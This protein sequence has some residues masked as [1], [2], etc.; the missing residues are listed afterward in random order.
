MEVLDHEGRFLD[1]VPCDTLTSIATVAR[2]HDTA[3][4]L[5]PPL[6]HIIDLVTIEVTVTDQRVFLTMMNVRD[7][8]N[9]IRAG[10]EST[11]RKDETM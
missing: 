11:K 1:H 7:D 3:L 6:A 4:G 2:L 9:V 10:H 8:E 5:D